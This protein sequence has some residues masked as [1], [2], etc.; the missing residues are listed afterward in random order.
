MSSKTEVMIYASVDD[1]CVSVIFIMLLYVIHN[2]PWCNSS[3]VWLVWF[4]SYLKNKKIY[5]T[6]K[7]STS[8]IVIRLKWQTEV[9][10]IYMNKI[11]Y[12][13]LLLGPVKLCILGKGRGQA[14]NPEAC[15]WL[16]DVLD[17]FLFQ[18]TLNAMK[19]KPKITVVRVWPSG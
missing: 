11:N 5:E 13:L 10:I 17:T 6:K 4:M 7:L 9:A 15:Q 19:S 16:V 1:I 14:P 18:K 12:M 2:I 8:T 3:M